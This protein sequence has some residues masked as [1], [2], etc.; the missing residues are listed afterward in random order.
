MS[1]RRSIAAIATIA[2]LAISLVGQSGP[3][4]ASTR[5]DPAAADALSVLRVTA[6]DPAK[7]A[8]RL[9][10]GGFDLLEA[11]AGDDLFVLGTAETQR[12]LAE[13]GYSVLVKE[14]IDTAKA[15]LAIPGYKSAD[16]YIGYLDEVAAKYPKLAKTYDVGDSW[17]KTQDPAKGN[18][19][20]VVCLT[21][22]R[23]GD[24]RLTPD[25]KKP[26]FFLMGTV[27]ARELSPTELADRW[28]TELVTK[29]GTDA[30][31]TALMDSTELWVLPL[32]NPDGREI[33]EGGA[34]PPYY[35]RKNANDTLGNC[36][37]PPVG[38]RQIGVDLNRNFDFNW[39][40]ISTS[41]Q[42]CNE[43]YRG[44]SAGS[45]PETQALQDLMLD[46]F[47]DRR[48]PG[49]DAAAPADTRG[50]MITLHSNSNLVIFPWGDT[51]KNSPN[52]AGLRSMGFRLSWHNKYVA[53]QPGEVLYSV[54]G[55]TDDWSYGTLGLPS[56]TFEIGPLT[57]PCSDFFPP[58]SCQD[59]FWKANRDA[60]VY[61]GKMARQPYTLSLGPNTRSVAVDRS[62]VPVGTPVKVS[63]TG[64]DSAYGADGT[65]QPASQN[66][67]AG[68]YFLD[69]APWAGGTAVPMKAADGTF[70]AD[71]EKVRAKVRTAGL[72]SG[73]H[74][75]YV[76]SRDAKGNWG[77]VSA[78]SFNIR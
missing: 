35:Q 9:Q 43:V 15:A 20:K 4:S 37:N 74:V 34:N 67:T 8:E 71:T 55:S 12:Q 1:V 54:S 25:S 22:R 68:Q 78:V 2:A 7:A 3:G 36:P 18:D 51:K 76:R 19:L 42:P 56:S 32:A 58:Y 59:G 23:P 77:P 73:R 66:V 33:A 31:I 26:R 39:G 44:P 61:A 75:L 21:K 40:P 53:G 6:A 62:R 41:R 47:P 29:Y 70:D 45:E 50:M 11:R 14:R 72:L 69:K 30:D 38:D 52:D 28:I 17:L 57:G 48:G 16:E 24:C 13:L 63:A 10:S 5:P 60:L 27:H 64:Q 46:L 49:R 65:A